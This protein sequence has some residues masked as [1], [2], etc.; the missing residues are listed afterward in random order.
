MSKRNWL[1]QIKVINRIIEL[2]E[3]FNEYSSFGGVKM[4]FET[5]ITI[6]DAIEKI[7]SRK[8]FLPAIQREF[9]WNTEQIEILFDSLM[10]DYPIGSFLFWYVPKENSK[11][12]EFYEFIRDY[13]ELDSR[14][15]PKAN[16]NGLDDIITILDG[17]QRLTALYIGLRGTYAYKLARR[18]YG[19]PQS[20]P[21]RKLYL[22]LLNTT[23]EYNS[24][25][26]DFRFLTDE[27]SK[28]RNENNFWFEVG[29]ILNFDEFQV[30]QYLI[31][32]GL[33]VSNFKEKSIAANKT[34][35][36]LH[37]I[38]HK[39]PL[40]NYYLEKSKELDKVLNVFIR[41]NNGGTKLNYTDLLLSIATAQWK[42]KDARSEII[43][44]VDDI[45]KIGN[46][47]NF[48]KDFVLK[49]CLVLADFTNI[50]FK[51]D[52]FKKDNMIKIEEKWDEITKAIYLAVTLVSTL[53][54][55]RET[56]TSH[57]SIIPIA[58]YLLK[59][60]NPSNFDQTTKQFDNRLLIQ[61]WLVKSLLKK[62][63]GAHPENVYRAIREIIGQ[64]QTTEKFPLARIIENFKGTEKSII[65][66]DDDIDNLLDYEYGQPYTFSALALLYP[67]LDF[68][69]K[70]HMDHIFPK[71]IFKNNQLINRGVKNENIDF[72]L[73]N[74]NRIGNLQLL[75]GTPNQEKY[76]TDFEVW[77][78]S[79]YP[80]EQRRKEYMKKNYIPE[81]I[82]LNISNF[83]MFI[84][85]REELI[86]KKFK[87]IL[88]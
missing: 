27:E 19:N 13:S 82:D 32:S 80:D 42:D 50:A 46:G 20:Y 87:E 54:Y 84:N 4:A 10:R 71:S 72:Y 5:P 6:K 16:I 26:Y 24:K 23:E 29:K 31:E 65:F 76:C 88:S 77:L 59:L 11:D 41:I 55:D 37:T 58:Y 47:F 51:I 1:K 44:F 66:V 61:K 48:D 7:H 57:N 30:N 73:E 34:L 60:G 22:N 45:N 53:G 68:R 14:H 15:N 78:K 81:D 40:I 67:T 38:I 17:Q 39:N 52:N 33:L 2:I 64:E 69:N 36:Q 79:T 49:A 18:R 35:F 3:L 25:Q 28:V 63:F 43:S 56:L 62:V 12:Y 74:Y 75:E 70:F 9:V 21:K 86:I 85:Q 8:Y 83:E